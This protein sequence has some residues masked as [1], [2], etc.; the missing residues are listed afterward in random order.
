MGT[1]FIIAIIILV[2]IVVFNSGGNRKDSYEYKVAME[3]KE[4]EERR[5]KEKMIQ[6][7]RKTALQAQILRE[8]KR[9]KKAIDLGLSVLWS[10]TN[11]FDEIE[12]GGGAKYSWG[13]IQ[14]STYFRYVD[15]ELNKKD[16]YRLK[17]ILGND[18]L[19]I[20]GNKEYDAANNMW[21][22]NWRLPQK[23]EIE[24]L[25]NQCEWEWTNI[26]GVYGY[27]VIG[28]NGNYIFL[29]VTG[30]Y[31]VGEKKSP[32]AGFYWSGSANED[33]IFGEEAHYLYFDESQKSHNQDGKRWHGM[34]IRPVWSSKN[35]IIEKAGC[36]G[37]C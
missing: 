9:Q 23:Y 19:S 8:K 1:V 25:I 5:F 27:K 13:S 32:K 15:S 7:Q 21:G 29:P 17:R 36:S 20:S 34:A 6:E 14:K 12:S 4:Q 33:D 28:T 35:E 30:E 11:M 37:W 26:N 31:V 22:D 18:D 16:K 2:L 10:D 3:K 24:E